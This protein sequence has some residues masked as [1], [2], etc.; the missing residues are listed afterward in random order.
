[1]LDQIV[2]RVMRVIRLDKTVFAEIE[3]DEAA[4]TEAFIVVVAAAFLAAIGQGIAGRSFGAFISRLLLGPIVGWLLWSWVTQV[5]GTKLFQGEAT[6]WEMARTLGYANAP[7]ALGLLAFIPCVGPIISL[8]AWVLSLIVG[9]YAVREALDL[10][11]D[12]SILTIIIGWIV[13]VVVS[14]VVG[15][16]FGAFGALL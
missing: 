7:T 8:A 5:V 13:V 1:M 9:F 11:T 15:V 3:H 2:A 4:N 14:I 6:F 10:P 16:V 12:K